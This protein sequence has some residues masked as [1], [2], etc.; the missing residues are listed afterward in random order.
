MLISVSA[1]AEFNPDAYLAKARPVVYRVDRSETY[2]ELYDD[3]GNYLGI[4]SDDPD[5]QFYID[6]GDIVEADTL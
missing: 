4:N 6:A 3:K 2:Y 1:K 5:I